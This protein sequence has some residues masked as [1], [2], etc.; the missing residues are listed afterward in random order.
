MCSVPAS[1]RKT[2]GK[3]TYT[4]VLFCGEQDIAPDCNVCKGIKKS[5]L[6]HGEKEGALDRNCLSRHKVLCGVLS[7]GD[8]T[9]L[10]LCKMVHL[11]PSQVAGL[12]LQACLAEGDS[13]YSASLAS[14]DWCALP[15]ESTHSLPLAR[16]LLFTHFTLRYMC[17]TAYGNGTSHQLCLCSVA[18][19]S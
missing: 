11:N 15:P 6:G 12:A 5:S 2:L 9:R 13:P 8:C 14:S 19:K 3:Q 1:F 4:E 17:I 18:C 10:A 7:S 16:D